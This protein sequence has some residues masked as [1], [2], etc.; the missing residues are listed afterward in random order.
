L[1]G[2][3]QVSTNYFHSQAPLR[4]MKRD[5]E[6]RSP[7]KIALRAVPPKILKI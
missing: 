2:Q 3:V 4:P 5:F 6:G 7:P 1:A